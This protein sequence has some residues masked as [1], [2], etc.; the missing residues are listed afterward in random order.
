MS[1]IVNKKDI[2]KIKKPKANSH[3]GENGSL[4]IIGGSKKYHGALLLSATIASKIVD[5]VYILSNPENY[6]VIQKI[7]SKLFEFITV[8]KNE[9]GKYVIL[10]DVILIGPGLGVSPKERKLVNE[11]L[12]KYPQKKFVIDAD[13]LK[14]VNK[15]LLNR[16]HILTPHKREFETLF[17]VKATEINAKKIAKRFG[18]IIVLK[19]KEDIIASSSRSKNNITGN[20]GMTKGGTGDVLA[21]LI[22]ALACKNSLFLS[23][24][25][26]AYLNGTAADKLKKRVSYYYSASDLIAEIPKLLS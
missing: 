8:L 11:L 9:L 2:Q 15:S 16:N 14:V 5:L 6:E 17:K 13:A 10:S 26:G 12:K 22:A 24:C 20:Q 23:A 4:L 18:C 21:G 7:K 1:N 19:G 25:A 3:K